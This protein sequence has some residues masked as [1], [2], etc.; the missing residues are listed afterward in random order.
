MRYK[1]NMLLLL[2]FAICISCTYSYIDNVEM[3]LSL[4]SKPVIRYTILI[5]ILL[6]GYLSEKTD[7]LP[8]IYFRY[9]TIYDYIEKSILIRFS[10]YLGCAMIINIS[11]IKSGDIIWVFMSILILACIFLLLDCIS[12]LLGILCKKKSYGYILTIILYATFEILFDNLNVETMYMI[13]SNIL[14]LPFVISI[15]ALIFGTII[16]NFACF[17]IYVYLIKS[18]DK[19]VSVL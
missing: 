2:F 16:L 1:V 3:Y 13:F 4:F 8:M 12:R 18:I 9:H 6:I 14:I 15:K 19:M 10:L 11:L 7:M 5:L 17:L